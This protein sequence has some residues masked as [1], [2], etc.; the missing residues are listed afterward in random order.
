MV[1]YC[2]RTVKRQHNMQFYKLFMAHTKSTLVHIPLLS[3]AA[4]LRRV[5]LLRDPDKQERY[6]LTEKP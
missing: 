4:R 2:A 5:A 3:S 6:V 1:L